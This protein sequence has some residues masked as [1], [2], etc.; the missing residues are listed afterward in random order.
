MTKWETESDIKTMPLGEIKMH[1][2]IARVHT[3]HE[4]MQRQKLTRIE[5]LLTVRAG[6]MGVGKCEEGK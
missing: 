6:E 3:E 5:P 4:D 1:V 2:Y